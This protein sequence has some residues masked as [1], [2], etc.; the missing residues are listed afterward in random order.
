MLRLVLIS[1]LALGA[2]L[3]AAQQ[4]A[5]S[6]PKS[7]TTKLP[8]AAAPYDPATVAAAIRDSYYHPDTLSGLDCSISVDWPAFFAAVKLNPTAD[9]LKAIQGLKTRSRAARD[10][11]PE[12]AFD[13]AGGPLD[14]KEQLEDGL[15][16]MLGGFYQTYWNLVASSPIGSA[17]ELA[18]IE[19]LP[20]GGVKVYTSS[21]NI[22]V[23]VTADKESTPTHYTLD[24]SAMRGTIDVQYAASPRPVPGDLRRISSMDLVEQIGTSTMNVKLS[25]DYQAVDGIYIPSH[26]S[27]TMVGA[28]SLSIDFSG[29][30][31]SKKVSAH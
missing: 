27:Y 26:V 4:P 3:L 30:S 28:Y 13:W 9:R 1:L 12:I 8:A 21:Q 22:N 17:A 19:P 14:N 18:K 10:K 15:K 16:Q 11:K 20:D 23:V 29:C 25:L 2:N 6:P 7:E 31:V 24:T 5:S